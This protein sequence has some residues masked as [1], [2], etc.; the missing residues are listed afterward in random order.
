MR[1]YPIRYD[2]CTAAT[3]SCF[4]AL[5]GSPNDGRLLPDLSLGVRSCVASGCV[6]SLRSRYLFRSLTGSELHS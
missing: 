2:F 1:A 5:L 6:S 3:N 4:D